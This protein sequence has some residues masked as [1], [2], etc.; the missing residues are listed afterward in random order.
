VDLIRVS[1]NNPI[2]SADEQA[3]SL[4]QIPGAIDRLADDLRGAAG[5][6]GEAIGLSHN[7]LS[8]EAT[9]NLEALHAYALGEQARDQGEAR[10]ALSFYQQAATLDPR[11]VQAQLR[12]VALYRKQH[13]EV[14]A[15][16]AA[17]LALA[18]SS[19]TSQ[20]TRLLAQFEYQMNASG[21]YL[22]AATR[23][24]S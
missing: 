24:S 14:A 2:A 15:A 22:R 11:F 3:Q 9:G 17:T 20:R 10:A 6:N 23:E 8:R 7:P 4:Q 12:L 1:S 21:D 18:S 16:G 19:T 13:A 5:E